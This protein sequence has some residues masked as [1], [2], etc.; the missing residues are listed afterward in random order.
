MFFLLAFS[1]PDFSVS[2]V[3][4]EPCKVNNRPESVF[5]CSLHTSPSAGAETAQK[6]LWFLTLFCK[7]KTLQ[8]SFFCATF[9]PEKQGN[10][11]NKGGV[12]LWAN[13]LY[14]CRSLFL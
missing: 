1:C 13:G 6:H 10:L 3:K 2:I 8:A 11:Q 9:E 14:P 7:K 4:R 12:F 5:P